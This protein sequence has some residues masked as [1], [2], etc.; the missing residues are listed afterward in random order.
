MYQKYKN[1]IRNA[2]NSSMSYSNLV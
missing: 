2:N 1:K